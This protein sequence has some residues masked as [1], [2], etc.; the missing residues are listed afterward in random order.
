MRLRSTLYLML[1]CILAL[2]SWL[3]SRPAVERQRA[4]DG[5]TLYVDGTTGNDALSVDQNS[6][7]TPWKTLHKAAASARDG[8]VV[9]VNKGV[10]GCNSGTPQRSRFQVLYNPAVNNVTFRANGRVELWCGSAGPLIGSEGR[11]DVKWIGDFFL[12]EARTASVP[13]TGLVVFYRG[14]RGVVD[15][16]EIKGANRAFEDN[17]NGVRVEQS[18]GVT[19]RN[20][21]AYGFRTGGA[22]GENDAAVMLYDSNDTVIEHNWFSDTGTG[23][24][25]KGAHPGMTQLRTIVRFNRIGPNLTRMGVALVD[26]ND[27]QVYQ[28]LITGNPDNSFGAITYYGLGGGPLRT[29]VYNNTIH[30]NDIGVLLR[31]SAQSWKEA[32]F[33]N[34]LITGGRLA[35]GSFE[36]SS[37]GPFTL[38]DR[39]VV[40]GQSE[41]FA[42]LGPANLG[43]KDWQRLTFDQQGSSAGPAYVDTKSFRL[44]PRSPALTIGRDPASGATIPVGMYIT[45][46]EVIGRK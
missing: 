39:N 21:R 14:H 41:H 34:N 6:Q 1:F 9:V 27:S 5:G 13:D 43:F 31:G 46:D 25:I 20:V 7:A 28:N 2:S 22:L 24:Y 42:S 32:V 30:G 23:V 26:A 29:K 45:G 16:A 35:W 11:T 17:H 19:I 8:D 3:Y 37:P 38:I 44:S 40:N 15:G 4:S 36:F 10:Y 12:D 33:Q 18:N